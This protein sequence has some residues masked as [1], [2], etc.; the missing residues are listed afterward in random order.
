MVVAK[1][2][3]AGAANRLAFLCT[4]ISLPSPA[5]A[6]QEPA[7][8][9]GAAV[10]NLPSRPEVEQPAEPTQ[11]PAPQIS[12]NSE[13]AL[14]EEPCSLSAYDIRVK[15]QRIEFAA[16]GGRPVNPVLAPLLHGLQADETGDQPINVVCRIRD[17]VNAALAEAGYVARVQVPSQ[18]LQNGTLNLVII[19]GKLVEIHLRGDVG[20]MESTL[21]E[22]L[23]RIKSLDPF[24]KDEAVRI[25]LLAND[26]PGLRV[27]MALRNAGGEP[28]A[29]I[30]EVTAEAQTA[31]LLF[32]VQNYG[33]RQLGREIATL[34]GEFYGLTGLADRTYISL[35]N[36]LQWRETHIGQF[37]HDL[38]LTDSG[39]RLG[40]RLTY[41]QSEPDLGTLRLRSR[42]L[43]GGVDLAVPVVKTVDGT[44]NLAGGFEFLNQVTRV[45]TA[46]SQLPLTRDRTRV[47]FGRLAGSYTRRLQD[48][49][50]LIS[51]DGYA[52]FRKGID[53]LGSND[54][55][56]RSGGYNPSRLDGDPMATVIKGEIQTRL[57]LVRGVGLDTAVFGQWANHPLLNL[58]EFSIGNFTYGRGYDPGS[59]GGDRAVAARV[60]PRFSL[61]AAGPVKLE[62]S[63]FYEI[64]GLWNLGRL[65]GTEAHRTLESVGGGARFVLPGRAILEIVYAKPLQKALVN[66]AERQPPRV[67]V[68]LTT[69]L[70]P[71]GDR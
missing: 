38:A 12:V 3:L 33:S 53:I 26:I 50:P 54:I 40:G 62:M 24:N 4:L 8:P 65:A 23:E 63:G 30:G 10:P 6:Q 69:K 59:N 60:E 19:A 46:D 31:Q 22:R 52:E 71:W 56:D 43:I 1:C 9:V 36:S 55:G 58:E 2:G 20:R 16:P 49:R 5:A 17:R 11:R 21:R 57:A 68:S 61:G 42:S 37:G 34:R 35:S 48:G 28:G 67:L 13:G 51:V 29:L 45:L 66:D 18:E 64:V 32:N 41:A 15:L 44:L 14:A 25:L 47:L 70:W 7:P 39:L 27:Q